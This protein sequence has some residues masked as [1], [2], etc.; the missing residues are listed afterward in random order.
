MVS[1][2]PLIIIIF[3][4]VLWNSSIFHSRKLMCVCVRV[5]NI[6]I[7]KKQNEK[8]RKKEG[9]NCFATLINILMLNLQQSFEKEKKN[10]D[11]YIQRKRIRGK[12]Y[13]WKGQ[14]ERFHAMFWPFTHSSHGYVVYVVFITRYARHATA[15]ITPHTLFSIS[16]FYIYYLICVPNHNEHCTPPHTEIAWKLK[17]K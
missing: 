3:F 16:I 4:I 17:T 15:R 8:K 14:T 1:R 10:Y 2:S 12:K 9:Y 11:Q 5:N 6:L 7:E 13:V